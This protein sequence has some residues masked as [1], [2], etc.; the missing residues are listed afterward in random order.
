MYGTKTWQ[1][2][3]QSSFLAASSYTAL[4]TELWPLHGPV[5]SC[6]GT[7]TPARICSMLVHGGTHRDIT[8]K[9]NKQFTLMPEH[10]CYSKT[11]AMSSCT[12]LLHVLLNWQQVFSRRQHILSGWHILFL[13]KKTW[14]K[15][16]KGNLNRYFHFSIETMGMYIVIANIWINVKCFNIWARMLEIYIK[17]ILK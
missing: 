9:N 2:R 4:G 16:C 14:K 13:E 8:M 3:A 5:I 12:W 15:D 17:I 11:V 10:G 7:T 1:Q 6:V